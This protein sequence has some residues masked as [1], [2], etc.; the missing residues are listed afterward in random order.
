KNGNCLFATNGNYPNPLPLVR[1]R[2]DSVSGFRGREVC[3]PV[4]AQ[5]MNSITDFTVPFYFHSDS[6]KYAGLQNIHPL[7]EPV[8]REDHSRVGDYDVLSLRPRAGW[9]DTLI[10][11]N[12][13]V[14]FELCV[15]PHVAGPASI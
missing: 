12:D 10:I 1:L 4:T 2:I 14:L 8:L 9:N 15:I 3:I 7:L 6:M 13:A 5:N 11:P